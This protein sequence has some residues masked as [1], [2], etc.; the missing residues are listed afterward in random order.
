[1]DRDAIPVTVREGTFRGIQL[2]VR[3]AGVTF[4]DVKVY[5]ANGSVED[6]K[7]RR[8]IPAGGETRVIDLDGRNRVITKVVFWYNTKPGRARR[9]TVELWGMH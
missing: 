9:A 1:M 8:H 5:Y 3:K 2:K 6:I 7:I 4:R